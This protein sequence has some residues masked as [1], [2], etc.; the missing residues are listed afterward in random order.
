QHVLS[1]LTGVG[2]DLAAA[3]Q[4]LED[5]GVRKFS[6]AFD[7]LQ[8]TLE[9]RSAA[10]TAEPVS[11]QT[12][13]LDGYTDPVQQRIAQFQRD[14]F[15]ERLCRTDASLWKSDPASQ[16]QIRESLGWLHVPE[17]MEEALPAL[18][19]FVSE[20]KAAG[21]KHVVHMGMGGSSL[22]PLVFERSFER[23]ADGL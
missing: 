23:P 9:E 19:A 13:D 11:S 22:A 17:V 1:R 6:D 14:T 8:A 20:V 3:T 5:E 18:H 15:G 10:A 12:L 4:Q 16:A 2:V 7:R 21:F